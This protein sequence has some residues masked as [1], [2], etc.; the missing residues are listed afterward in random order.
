MATQPVHSKP[1]KLVEIIDRTQAKQMPRYHQA[2]GRLRGGLI[3]GDSYSKR[4]IFPLQPPGVTGY[5]EKMHI[6]GELGLRQ[7]IDVQARDVWESQGLLGGR[8]RGEPTVC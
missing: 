7:N 1:F 3:A 5:N 6:E 2:R 8:C 4:L